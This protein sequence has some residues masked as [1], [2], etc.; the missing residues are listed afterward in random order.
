M[1]VEGAEVDILKGMKVFLES[2][3]KCKILMELHPPLYSPKEFLKSFE[4]LFKNGFKLEKFVGSAFAHKHPLLKN[5]HIP[6]E[7]Y[8]SGGFTRAVYDNI[9][10]DDFYKI[11][12]NKIPYKSLYNFPTYILHPQTLLKPFLNSTK[13]AR[14][15]LFVK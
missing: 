9:S 11:I 14:A 2:S 4:L 7:K 1:D 8:K 3:S 10:E 5:N 12:L 6:T 13:L 15:A